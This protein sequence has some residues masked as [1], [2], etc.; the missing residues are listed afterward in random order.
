MYM[1]SVASELSVCGFSSNWGCPVRDWIMGKWGTRISEFDT[2]R[3]PY[4]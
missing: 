1:C 2:A 3:R 4:V